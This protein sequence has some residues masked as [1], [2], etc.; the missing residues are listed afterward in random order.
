[1]GHADGGLH[2]CQTVIVADIMVNESYLIVLGLSAQI[3]RAV[4]VLAAVGE[5]H[6][7]ATGGD[8]LVA[9]E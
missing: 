6:A 9:V 8:D 4:G 2:V 3:F 5:D 7:S 1:M